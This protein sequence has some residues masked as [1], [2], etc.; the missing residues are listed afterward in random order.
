MRFLFLSIFTFIIL[1]S[2]AQYFLYWND[3]FEQAE[4]NSANWTHEIGASG[5]GNNELQY[6]TNSPSN[7]FIENGLLKIRAKNE[8]IF[9]SQYSSARMIS[10]G[11]FEFRYGRIEARIKVP[12]GQ[13]L[14]PAFWLLGANISQ[15]SWPACGEVD[16]MEHIGNEYQNYG[17]FHFDSL[18]HRYHGGSYG[19]DPT[20]F[21]QYAFVWTPTTMTWLVDNNPYYSVNITNGIGNK[22]E[23]HLPFFILLNI[24]VG[25]NWPGSPSTSTIFPAEMQ[26][27]YIRVYKDNSELGLAENQEPL[28]SVYPN[29]AGTTIK[30]QTSNSAIIKDITITSSSGQTIG[31]RAINLL[32]EID[33]AD[34]LPGLYFITCID[35][36]DRPYS[37]RFIKE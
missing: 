21:H 7:S 16:I 13:G 29:P 6:Y 25:G 20:L 12:M 36:S 8:P 23:F 10:K 3:E 27:D 28:L 9:N 37:T 2:Q 15:V 11:K 18:G 22:E 33:V 24:A 30:V 4:I 32:G 19:L 17:T 35:E 14:W 26:I 34:L 31:S 1:N 5:W